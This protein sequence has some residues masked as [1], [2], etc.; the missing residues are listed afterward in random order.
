MDKNYLAL[1]VIMVLLFAILAGC[2]GEGESDDD[3]PLSAT[4]DDTPLSAT[5]D[6]TPLSA[7]VHLVVDT[8]YAIGKVQI[9]D[10]NG[11]PCALLNSFRAGGISCD[12]TKWTG[13]E[14]TGR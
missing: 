14:G 2:G 5:V 11:M 12:W 13:T 4:V 1:L 8:D 9:I 10:I 6:D 7:T 3:T